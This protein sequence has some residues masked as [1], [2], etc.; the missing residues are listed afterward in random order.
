MSHR[1]EIGFVILLSLYYG[2]YCFQCGARGQLGLGYISPY[3]RTL[4]MS[5]SPIQPIP[6][7][8]QKKSEG[9]GGV[10]L[11]R[12]KK[13]ER[14]TARRKSPNDQNEQEQQT[15]TSSTTT[16]TSDPTKEITEDWSRTSSLSDF[17]SSS[18]PQASQTTTTPPSAKPTDATST[19]SSTTNP[20]SRTSLTASVPYYQS[21]PLLTPDEEV[22][23]GKSIQLYMSC[24]KVYLQL[25]A[26]GKV[27]RREGKG[28]EEDEKI[29]M[30]CKLWG[31][32]C[33]YYDRGASDDGEEGDDGGALSW[34]ILE[35][36]IPSKYN[37]NQGP[38]A[39]RESRKS[40]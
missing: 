34:S 30:Y 21:A 23:L 13:G 17:T 31:R 32:S 8:F 20:K 26:E 33:G 15:P 1:R 25:E 14:R 6:P 12:K 3:R 36:H 27:G 5:T 19:S 37:K 9:I 10:R 4:G 7:A 40:R 22:S 39:Q 28:R 2:C 29:D 24:K 18:P 35:S 38:G 11:V 16:S